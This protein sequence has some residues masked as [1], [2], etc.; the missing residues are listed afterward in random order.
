MR[1]VVLGLVLFASAAR[2]QCT[3]PT[4]RKEWSAMST[5]EKTQYIEAVKQLDARPDSKQT[6]DPTRMSNWWESD[7]F[8][9]AYFGGVGTSAAVCLGNGAFNA[10]SGYVIGKD[11]PSG[12]N[13]AR[14]VTGSKTCLRRC[15]SQGEALYD[16]TT[17]AN[18]ILNVATN[19]VSFRGDDTTGYHAAGHETMG[20][21]NCD[22][23]NPGY[24][25]NDPIFFL[26]HGFVDKVWYL[27]QGLCPEFETDY[28]G[29]LQNGDPIADNG[30]WVA[31]SAERL[32]SWS[33]YV[34]SDVLS[35][36]AGKLCYVYDKSGIDRVPMKAK[37]C[38]GGGAVSRPAGT[39]VEPNVKSASNATAAMS[40]NWFEQLLMAQVPA[41]HL[42]Q[43]SLFP[44]PNPYPTYGPL[45][46]PRVA[47]SLDIAAARRRDDG[48]NEDLAA[49]DEPLPRLYTTK[50]LPTGELQ[51]LAPDNV[52]FT[53]PPGYK[54]HRV[55]P[56]RVVVLL[57]S[58]HF[59]GTTPA[60]HEQ[61]HLVIHRDREA[62]QPPMYE[63]GEDWKPPPT[64]P[65][66]GKKLMYP[67]YPSR[68]FAE[69]HGNDWYKVL[70]HYYETIREI[71][72]FNADE[73]RSSPSLDS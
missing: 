59:N 69:M 44:D 61:V 34:V 56:H 35:T 46:H 17:I 43:R 26:H 22:M 7:V 45:L 3:N 13:S 24:S 48:D 72:R 68:T 70:E 9:D 51:V 10:K 55:F 62:E 66:H 67:R 50:P 27:W 14:E 23:G 2:S 58:Y 29:T 38:P 49:D 42:K 64:T 65:G 54:I 25:P 36:T 39:D 21:P 53:I 15:G 57:S 18:T 20:G 5:S 30:S 47:R 41:S 4:I 16:A 19:Y 11:P 40:I 12:P 71:D 33:E 1:S 8:S 73:G 60:M 63:P 52:T 31:D 32:D 28:E 6:T 37:S